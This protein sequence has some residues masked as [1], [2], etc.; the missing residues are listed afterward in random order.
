MDG[1][2]DEFYRRQ[3]AP[4]RQALARGERLDYVQH[5]VQMFGTDSRMRVLR[6][7]TIFARSFANIYVLVVW[8]SGP[9]DETTTRTE[10]Q[11]SLPRVEAL[12]VSLPPP[13]PEPAEGVGKQRA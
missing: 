1:L 4:R 2:A 8:I 3:I 12:T 9:Y 7:Y 11:R 13:S 6:P 5:G 10:M